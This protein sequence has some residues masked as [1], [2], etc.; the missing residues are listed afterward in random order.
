MKYGEIERQHKELRGT[1]ERL[2]LVLGDP[3]GSQGTD[4]LAEARSLE[5]SLR[6]HFE[7]EEEDGYLEVVLESQPGWSR[8]VDRL[9][10]QHR[11]ILLELQQLGTLPF[12]EVPAGLR[13]ALDSVHR[14]DIEESDLVSEA[15]TVELG[16]AD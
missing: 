4:L 6:E 8:R 3:N 14:H 16:A 7:C 13:H 12:D 2:R 15:V 9:R 11:A 1:M 10:E 5:S